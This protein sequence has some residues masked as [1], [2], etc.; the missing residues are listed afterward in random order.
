[1]TVSGFDGRARLASGSAPTTS[2]TT[3]RV[4]VSSGSL[5]LGP[6]DRD[7]V[8]LDVPLA[9][10][11][12]RPLGRAGSV[13]VDV[14]HSPLLLNFSEHQD[15]EEAAGVAARLRRVVDAGLGRRRRDR[16][17]RALDRGRS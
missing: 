13:V 12:A 5:R 15:A 9:R 10:V 7:G 6:G 3:Y 8:V 1:M 17:L 16:F 11:A 2:V 14:D 4:I